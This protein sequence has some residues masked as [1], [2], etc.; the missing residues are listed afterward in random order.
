MKITPVTNHGRLR[1]RVNVQR[2]GYRRRLFFASREE[3]L[4][5]AE[6]AGSPVKISNRPPWAVPRPASPAAARTKP[7]NFDWWLK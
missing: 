1:W 5:F 3:A 4:A 2:G 6:A 7:G